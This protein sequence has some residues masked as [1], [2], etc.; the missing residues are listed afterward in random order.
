M[1]KRSVTVTFT[2]LSI[3]GALFLGA[4]Q[5][6]ESKWACALVGAFCVTLDLRFTKAG[7]KPA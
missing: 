6:A 3:I 7:K 1:K 4:A 5:F 2:S